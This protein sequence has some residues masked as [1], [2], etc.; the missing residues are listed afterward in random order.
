MSSFR[1]KDNK[2]RHKETIY[3]LDVLHK[4]KMNELRREKLSINNKKNLLQKYEIESN[5]LEN[6]DHKLYT[7]NDIRQRSKL[8]TSI[9]KLKHEIN[10]IDHDINELLYYSDAGIILLSYYSNPND[11][12]KD[13]VNLLCNMLII[14][15]SEIND[16]FIQS[17]LF[18][19]NVSTVIEI[20]VGNDVVNDGVE[21]IHS[22]DANQILP[23]K[24]IL[25]VI[26]SGKS[27]NS[28]NKK[29]KYVSKKNIKMQQNVKNDITSYL[30]I[31]TNKTEQ[32]ENTK[33]TYLKMYKSLIDG[34]FSDT[35]SDSND[36]KY[37]KNCK[38]EK[39]IIQPEGFYVCDKCGDSEI[40]IINN[41]KMYMKNG[42]GNKEKSKYP[43]QRINHFNEWLSQFQAKETTGIPN[44]VYNDIINELAKQRIKTKDDF[45]KI[46]PKFMKSILKKLDYTL[47]YEH[48][49]RIICRLSGIHPPIISRDIEEQLKMMF[50]QIQM[51]FEKYKPRKR[52]NFLSY[53]YVLHKFCLLLELDDYAKCFSLLK[54]A[55]KLRQYEEIWKKI[56]G[57]LKWEF[58]SSV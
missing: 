35:L 10:V 33:A 44:S 34:D 57:D 38:E 31:K 43:Y 22:V 37:C 18:N 50:K 51:P 30:N 54:S 21:D 56:C 27:I 11:P 13:D 46:K 52:K 39:I 36:L 55:N 3:T 20:D 41:D 28:D 40:M 9:E 48:S 17:K 53:S 6:K 26:I 7:T 47:Y 19:D 15:D 1:I 32:N 29:N 2:T 25:D 5:N 49:T 24:S 16:N 23:N 42:V 45:T 58:I 4:K 8:K 14:D 12:V